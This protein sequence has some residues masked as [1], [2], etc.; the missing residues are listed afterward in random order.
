MYILA[1]SRQLAFGSHMEIWEWID[2]KHI[3]GVGADPN[4]NMY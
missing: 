3:G 2:Q 1:V 4:A